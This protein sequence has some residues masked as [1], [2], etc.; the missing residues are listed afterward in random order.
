MPI[1]TCAGA[2]ADGDSSTPLAPGRR[3]GVVLVGHSL[4]AAGVAS[5]FV[6]DPEGVAGIVLVAPAIIVSPFT[7]SPK[8]RRRAIMCAASAAAARMH[9]LRLPDTHACYHHTPWQLSA[10]SVCCSAGRRSCNATHVVCM[11][12]THELPADS[13]SAEAWLDR[14]K[15]RGN[16]RHHEMPE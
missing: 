6:Q 10:K 14:M 11:H 12:G 4:G 3:R 16:T 2:G 7:V 8:L 15:E 1:R 9:A 5:S 13:A